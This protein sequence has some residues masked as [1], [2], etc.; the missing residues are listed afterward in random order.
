M[1]WGLRGLLPPRVMAEEE[2]VTRVL[3]NF[4]RKTPIPPLDGIRSVSLHIAAAFAQLACDNGLAAAPRPEDLCARIRRSRFMRLTCER[5]PQNV[6]PGSDV[7][8][9]RAGCVF[10]GYFAA[11]S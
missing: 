5:A 7:E 8:R 4:R 9:F 6:R 11:I 1:R 10:R 2:P 3:D